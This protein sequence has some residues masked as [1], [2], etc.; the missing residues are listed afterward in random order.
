MST[1]GRRSA[2]RAGRAVL[3]SP[4]RPSVARREERRRVW[5]A[6]AV[7]GSRE[8]AAIT[9]GGSPAVGIRWFRETGGMSPSHL[10]PSSPPRPARYLPITERE[11][12][13]ILR[14]H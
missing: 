11:Q 14:T 4:G 12:L 6:I 9:G 2:E 13:A 7:G 10:A 3:R 8:D 1:K 5:V